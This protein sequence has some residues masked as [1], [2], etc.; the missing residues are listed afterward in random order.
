MKVLKVATLMKTRRVNLIV[1]M[2]KVKTIS[3][4][5]K[6][7]M[8]LDRVKKVTKKRRKLKKAA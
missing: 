1:L 4:E 6:M 8:D 2:N 3:L 5:K 7:M